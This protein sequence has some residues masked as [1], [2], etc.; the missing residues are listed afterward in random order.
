MASTSTTMS[1]SDEHPEHAQRDAA[2]LLGDELDAVVCFRGPILG[3]RRLGVV[4]HAC[5]VGTARAG[6]RQGF[7]FSRNRLMRRQSATAPTRMPSRNPAITST[8][9]VPSC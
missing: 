2:L 8:G 9:L 4:R 6:D 5:S 7:V 3:D 1:E